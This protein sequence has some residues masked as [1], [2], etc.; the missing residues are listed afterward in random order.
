MP[1]FWLQAGLRLL[2]LALIAVAAAF[3][4]DERAGWAIFSAGL[5]VLVALQLTY[6]RRLQRWLKDPDLVEIPEGWG[7]WNV[8]FSTLYRSRRHE[9]A[10][11]RGLTSA[12]H[13]FQRA[14]GALPDG[15][16]L[17]DSGLH[18]V[19]CNTAAESHFGIDFRRDQRL[20]F[21]HIARHPALAD[22][23]ELEVGAP[24]VSIRPPHN[25]SQ[26]LSLQLIP[27]GESDRLLL[28]RDV[29]AIE[30][31]E[32]I[33]RD[34]V[35][36]V[37]HELRTPL[38]VLTGFIEL[39][40]DEIPVSP[41]VAKRQHQLMREQAEQMARL[42]EDLLTLS[43]LEGD[44][45][46]AP[47]IEVDIPALLELLRKDAE[48]LSAG[49]H[50]FTWEIDPYL[51][52]AGTERDLRSVFTNLVSNAIRYTPAG[53]N[54]HV[55]WELHNGSAE[56][57]VRDSG[58]GI[59]PEHIS[60]LTER[61]YRVDTGRSRESGGTG[62]GLAIVKHVLVRHQGRL[63][64]DSEPGRGSLFRA[65]FPPRRVRHVAAETADVTDVEAASA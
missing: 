31:A 61:F 53:G 45:G 4:I 3:A 16:V 27:F 20:L 18:I 39:L 42:V 36:N 44:G 2:G 48:S 52:I 30:R 50:L 46:I 41:A 21:T 11:R 47:N 23:L 10:S 13:R 5:L 51:A 8:V 12:L 59:A 58:I 28:S 1:E 7:G 43:R 22:Y 40:G 32:T 63:D 15:V 25:P 56:F 65:A 55:S 29:T 19:W 9:E 6:L 33:R 54:I 64:I 37:S 14:A 24:P 17:L 60:R 26:M 62:L 35:A 57:S 34:F 49:H 38:T